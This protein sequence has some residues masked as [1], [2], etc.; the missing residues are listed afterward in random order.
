MHGHPPGGALF[1]VPE[2]WV[3]IRQLNL[4]ID[5]VMYPS[6]INFTHILQGNRQYVALYSPDRV[7]GESP[8]MSG[9]YFVTVLVLVFKI[10][11]SLRLPIKM[12]PD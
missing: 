2:W 9:I 12:K 3:D 10:L 5:I 4:H 6:T 1:T 11:S 8:V 7:T